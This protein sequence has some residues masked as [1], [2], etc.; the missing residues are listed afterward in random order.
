MSGADN[1][2]AL[3]IGDWKIVSN[4][5]MTKFMLFD[6]QKDW[7]EKKDLAGQMP[8]KLEE[9]KKALFE[10]WKNIEQEGPKEWW[11]NERQKPVKGAKLNY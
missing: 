7:K 5:T 6:I 10:V 1:R 2:V 8:E 11:L 3:R 9:L 4:D